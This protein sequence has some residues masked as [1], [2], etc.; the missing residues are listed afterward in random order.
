[1][2]CL[3]NELIAYLTTDNPLSNRGAMAVCCRVF[4]LS[5]AEETVKLGLCSLY[6]GADPQR[7]KWIPI[8]TVNSA[9]PGLTALGGNTHGRVYP[10]RQDWL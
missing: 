6:S 2:N 1:M 5:G 8:H 9:F 7:A 3:E 10:V 4:F